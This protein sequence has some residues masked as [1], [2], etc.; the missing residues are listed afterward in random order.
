VGD[1]LELVA[2]VWSKTGAFS[3]FVSWLVVLA[4]PVDVGSSR[5]RWLPA[6][7][8]AI[9]PV[10]R[11]SPQTRMPVAAIQKDARQ[12]VHLAKLKTLMASNKP[13]L[14]RFIKGRAMRHFALIHGITISDRE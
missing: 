4:V 5:W 7:L 8:S 2:G 6:V 14:S 9:V 11:V 13:R 1:F 12:T 10:F 3:V